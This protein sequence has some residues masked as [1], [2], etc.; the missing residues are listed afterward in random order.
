MKGKKKS[1]GCYPGSTTDTALAAHITSDYSTSGAANSIPIFVNGSVIGQVDGDVFRKTIRGSVHMLRRP[2]AI[3]FDVSTLR[4]AEAAG[5]RFVLVHDSDSGQDYRAPLSTVWAKGF[6]VSRGWG[7]Q[8][9]LRVERFNEDEK[10]AQLRLF[11]G[12]A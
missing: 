1:P 12:T 4:D 5:A 9:A 7:D 10:P 2:R 6:R 8:W 11:G 3:A